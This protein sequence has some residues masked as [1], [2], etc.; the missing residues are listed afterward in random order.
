MKIQKDLY[1]QVFIVSNRMTSGSYEGDFSLKV[2][3]TV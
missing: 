2:F 3:N 1:V